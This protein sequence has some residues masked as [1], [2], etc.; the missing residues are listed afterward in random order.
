MAGYELVARQLAALRR[1]R[2][3]SESP[4]VSPEEE[5][6]NAEQAAECTMDMAWQDLERLM[7]ACHGC[8]DDTEDS[9]ATIARIQEASIRY[10]L[11]VLEHQRLSRRGETAQENERPEPGEE[12]WVRAGVGTAK[13]RHGDLIVVITDAK[14]SNYSIDVHAADVLDWRRKPIADGRHRCASCGRAAQRDE[15]DWAHSSG[16]LCSECLPF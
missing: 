5:A 16:P 8:P 7:E 3:A 14:A 13:A 1:S 15:L 11:A 2:D 9:D 10:G 4:E 6:H 12:V